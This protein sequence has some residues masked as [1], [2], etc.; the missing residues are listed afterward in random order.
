MAIRWR[1]Y[2]GPLS[3][4]VVVFNK[5]EY[6]ERNSYLFLPRWGYYQTRNDTEHNTG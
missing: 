5:E 2:D 1:A 6:N 4:L 3:D